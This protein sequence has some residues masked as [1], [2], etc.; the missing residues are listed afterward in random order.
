MVWVKTHHRVIGTSNTLHV[1]EIAMREKRRECLIDW[2]H[3][4]MA[5][6]GVMEYIQEMYIDPPRIMSLYL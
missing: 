6:S 1:S 5:F 4:L 3:F 2:S